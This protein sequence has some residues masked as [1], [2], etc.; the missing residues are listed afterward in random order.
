VFSFVFQ[1]SKGEG[2]SSMTRTG[3]MA[4]WSLFKAVGYGRGIGVLCFMTPEMVPL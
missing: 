3:E 4:R 2:G 1:S